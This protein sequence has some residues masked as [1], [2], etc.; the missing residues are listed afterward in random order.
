MTDPDV[1]QRQLDAMNTDIERVSSQN[2]KIDK[3]K[4]KLKLE[5]DKLDKMVQ[6]KTK[7]FNDATNNFNNHIA[8][9]RSWRFYEPDPAWDWTNE[10]CQRRCHAKKDQYPTNPNIGVSIDW[11]K[12]GRGWWC[13]C[14]LPNK[15]TANNLHNIIKAKQGELNQAK[16][17]RDTKKT[18]YEASLQT[19]YTQANINVAC[20]T[21]ST[22]CAPGA[23]CDNIQQ[24]CQAEITALI[25]DKQ[26]KEAAKEAAASTNDQSFS[27]TYNPSGLTSSKSSDNKL[28]FIGGGS[29]SLCFC[30]VIIIIVIII[31]ILNKK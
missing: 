12:T 13:W 30:S 19:P 18:Q 5:L 7:E 2:E 17:E 16:V 29:S 26:K 6:Q 22:V 14:H 10:Q 28:L 21:N 4:N 1:C 15:E 11:E 23:E 9:D 31:L 25:E 24:S 8:N 3:T 27:S 20:C